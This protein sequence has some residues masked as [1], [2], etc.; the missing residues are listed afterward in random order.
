MKEKCPKNCFKVAFEGKGVSGKARRSWARKI[1]LLERQ[2]YECIEEFYSK[3]VGHM[4]R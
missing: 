4:R 1:V 3:A 2:N